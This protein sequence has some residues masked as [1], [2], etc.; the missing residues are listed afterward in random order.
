MNLQG[1]DRGYAER[2]I[3]GEKERLGS[4]LLNLD[5][6]G[7]GCLVVIDRLVFRY[8]DYELLF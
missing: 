3:I 8:Y 5:V 7:F 1:G 2:R 6:V 4:E